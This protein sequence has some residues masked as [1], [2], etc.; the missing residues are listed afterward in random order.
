MTTDTDRLEKLEKNVQ[1]LM[2]RQAIL[3]CCARNARGCDRYDEE[4][5]ASAY[6]SDGVDEHGNA[7]NA[8]P[9]YPAWANAQHAQGSIQ[10]LHHITHQNC[11]ID[12]DT[13]HC[14]TY[15]I[16][17][18]LQKGGKNAHILSGRYID[19][20]EKRDGEWKIALRRSTAEVFMQADAAMITSPQFAKFGFLKGLQDKTDLSYSRPLTLD[21]T[22]ENHRW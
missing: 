7:I 2:D 17:L 13:A 8:G 22:P 21:E 15:V 16:G 18:F 14:E 12:G 19:R 3:D 6:H 20:L 10:H 11:E 4:L 5:L 9:D 1:F